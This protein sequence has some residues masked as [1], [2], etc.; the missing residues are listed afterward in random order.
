[1]ASFKGD[2]S[3]KP[4]KSFLFRDNEAKRHKTQ[5]PLSDHYPEPPVAEE[6]RA[7]VAIRSERKEISCS[8]CQES[9]P[10]FPFLLQLC[11]NCD[12]FFCRRC[13]VAAEGITSCPKCKKP[14][15]K[16]NDNRMVAYIM[17]FLLDISPLKVS[18]LPDIKTLDDPTREKIEINAT[19]NEL[20]ICGVLDESQIRAVYHLFESP[21]DRLRFELYAKNINNN[22]RELKGQML[23]IDQSCI[24]ICHFNPRLRT[25]TS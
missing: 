5:S 4:E 8:Q 20:R 15:T 22:F 19:K 9:H 7:L 18:S 3:H 24:P 11:D 6:I 17:D 2:G 16:I 13:W 12:R 10:P 14:L 23:L 1:M 21:D 25:H